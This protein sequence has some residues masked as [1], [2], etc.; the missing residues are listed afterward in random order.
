M[1]AKDDQFKQFELAASKRTV[2]AAAMC[3]NV[4]L[5]QFADAGEGEASKQVPIKLLGRTGKPIAHWYWG[6]VVHDMDGMKLAKDSLPIDYCH[7]P[8]EI[9]GYLNKFDT[10][11]GD[12]VAS[13]E[14]VLYA[15]GDRAS[16][17]A[18]KAKAGVPYEASINFAG[19]P[20]RL[21]EI[22]AGITVKVNGNDVHG[23]AL[24]IREWTLRGI[25]VCPYGADANTKTE[26]SAKGGEQGTIDVTIFK[27]VEVAK[28]N[29]TNKPTQMTNVPAVSEGTL[30]RDKTAE[31]TQTPAAVKPTDN[32]GEASKQLSQDKPA[33]E[34]KAEPKPG[35]E[36]VAAFGDTGAR[37]YLEGRQFGECATEFI[38]G[39]DKKIAELSAEVE[40]L[41]GLL[42]ELPRGNEP[43]SF[44]AGSNSDVKLPKGVNGGA[45]KAFAVAMQARKQ[46]AQ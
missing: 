34:P 15:D 32:H 41:K 25:A 26:L 5:M 9:L 20:L 39:K 44:K 43:V 45:A 13:G 38:A 40:K 7:F 6:N 16:E 12:L 10:S 24:I 35:A 8:D 1:P 42:G 46:P 17:V 21:E 4:G 3:F 11:S 37:W 18:F 22:E 19:G 31:L 29:E 33:G 2:P 14:L 30:P 27:E 28:A 23:P 36:F